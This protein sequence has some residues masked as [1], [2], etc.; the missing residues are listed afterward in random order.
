MFKKLQSIDEVVEQHKKDG[1]VI[2]K[3][4]KAVEEKKLKDKDKIIDPKLVFATKPKNTKKGGWRK[5]ETKDNEIKPSLIKEYN[6]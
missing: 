3:K 2:N 1:F 6:Y 4:E 5:P